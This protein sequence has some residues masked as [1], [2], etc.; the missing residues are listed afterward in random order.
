[1]R[2]KASKK[3]IEQLKKYLKNYGKNIKSASEGVRVD[4]NGTP[5]N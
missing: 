5:A 1:M 3:Q 2:F 4:S